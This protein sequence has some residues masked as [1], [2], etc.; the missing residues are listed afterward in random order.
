MRSCSVMVCALVGLAQALSN[1]ANTR[2]GCTCQ[3][4]VQSAGSKSDIAPPG[5][6]RV[7]DQRPDAKRP[8]NT[9]RVTIAISGMT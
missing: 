9:K 6:G 4:A 7:P 8:G 5:P 3:E 1:H 2:D